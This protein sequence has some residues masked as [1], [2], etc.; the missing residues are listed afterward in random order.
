MNGLHQAEGDPLPPQVKRLLRRLPP[1]DWGRLCVILGDS[2]EVIQAAKIAGRLR[3]VRKAGAAA[4]V[5][6][7]LTSE[8][9]VEEMRKI[10]YA[11]GVLAERV[12][13]FLQRISAMPRWRKAM[14][15]EKEFDRWPG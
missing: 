3:T 7:R 15:V 6:G 9:F 5:R 2:P 14:E 12:E 13:K 10:R 4:L 1:R 11:L 8:E